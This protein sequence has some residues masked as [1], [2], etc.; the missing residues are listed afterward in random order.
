M[1]LFSLLVIASFAILFYLLFPVGRCRYLELIW[2]PDS[3]SIVLKDAKG[4]ATYVESLEQV[5]RSPWIVAIKVSV[6]SRYQT[7][8]IFCWRY[9]CSDNEWRKLQVLSKLSPLFD[10]ELTGQM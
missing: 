8:W 9:C 3:S 2:N 1:T 4:I 5:I 6:S 10:Q 7:D